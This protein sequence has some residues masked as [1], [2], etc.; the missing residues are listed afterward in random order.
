MSTVTIRSL[1]RARLFHEADSIYSLFQANRLLASSSTVM[2]LKSNSSHKALESPFSHLEMYGCE[3]P[4]SSKVGGG[5]HNAKAKSRKGT[6][7]RSKT[8]VRSVSSVSSSRSSIVSTSSKHK[9]KGSSKSKS[10]ASPKVPIQAKNGIIRKGNETETTVYTCTSKSTTFD[11]AKVDHDSP[12]LRKPGRT[13]CVS[14]L[15]PRNGAWTRPKIGVQSPSYDKKPSSTCPDPSTVSRSPS[16]SSAA[17]SRSLLAHSTSTMST[18]EVLLRFNKGSG[19]SGILNSS[20]NIQLNRTVQQNPPHLHLPRRAFDTDS[21]GGR[22]GKGSS[23]GTAKSGPLTIEDVGMGLGKMQ[24]RNVIVMSGAGI[25]TTS[26]IP[27]F[28]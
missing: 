17:S 4:A 6:G 11:L 10:K 7:S 16:S 25:S 28:R 14:Q 27:D 15:H 18:S 20:V 13:T 1:L 19:K 12:I 3:H 5:K 24:Y 9:N 21:R 22:P 26:G 8:S 23:K 2:A